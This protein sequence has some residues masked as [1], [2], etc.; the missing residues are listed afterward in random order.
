MR[1][2]TTLEGSV[3]LVADKNYVTLLGNLALLAL[4]SVLYAHVVPPFGSSGAAW[5]TV[6]VEGGSMVFYMWA[7]RRFV[8]V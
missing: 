8:W 7:S 1:A 5:V 2:M 6:A 4:A 3:L